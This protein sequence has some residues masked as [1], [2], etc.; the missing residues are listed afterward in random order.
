MRRESDTSELPNA[1]EKQIEDELVRVDF[2]ID[3]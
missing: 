2:Y 1:L 3:V